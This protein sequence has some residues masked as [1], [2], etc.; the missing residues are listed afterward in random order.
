[1]KTRTIAVIAAVAAVTTLSCTK[2][3]LEIPRNP[4]ELEFAPA[5][6]TVRIDERRCY[7]D[8]TYNIPEDDAP[9]LT[10]WNT[11]TITASSDDPSF[12]GVNVA[13]SDPAVMSVERTDKP[14][15]YSVIYHSDGQAE[16]RVWNPAH[17]ETITMTS[18]HTIELE[19]IRMRVE[20]KEFV[21]KADNKLPSPYWSDNYLYSPTPI[22]RDEWIYFNDYDYGNVFNGDTYTIE[23]IDIVPENAS[24][25][26]I[27]RFKITDV[28]AKDND[29]SEWF[30]YDSKMDI[31]DV[32]AIT[33]KRIEKYV[34]FFDENNIANCMFMVVAFKTN[35]K[36]YKTPIDQIRYTTVVCGYRW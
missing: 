28:T 34:T 17:E 9:V 23:I 25:R 3:G 35:C 20:G 32:S 1:M 19:G 5:P 13:S 2:I 10:Y 14:G 27:A 6:F 29:Y 21:V 26:M 31:K 11:V 30:D 15:V 4:E 22:I 12:N 36:D 33:N 16:L 8:Y 24:W 7:K 18:Q